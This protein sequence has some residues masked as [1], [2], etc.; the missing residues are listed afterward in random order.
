MTPSWCWIPDL[1][2]DQYE[3][4]IQS[5]PYCS[6]LQ[7]PQWSE[8]KSQWRVIRPA[9]L[10]ENRRILACGQVLIRPLPLGWSLWYMPFGPMLDYDEPKLLEIYLDQLVQE[11][12]KHPV[13]F[14]RIHPPVLVRE[15]RIEAFRKGEAQ[16]VTDEESLIKRF[17]TCGFA[18]RPRSFCLED[19]VQPRFQAVVR[20]E[21]WEEPPSSKIRYA[22]K[23]GERYRIQI[24]SCGEE[25]TAEFAR[26]IQLTEER[27][28]IILRNQTYFQ[29]LMQVYQE[30]ARYYLAHFQLQQVL[31]ETEAR[32]ESIESQQQLLTDTNPKKFRQLEEQRESCEKDLNFLRSINPTSAEAPSPSECLLDGETDDSALSQTAQPIAGILTLRYGKTAEMPYAG[33]DAQYSRIPS[34]WS[35]YVTGIREAFEAGCTRYNLGGVDGSL[36]DGLTRF[37][38][39]FN[40]TI[41]E[42]IGEFDYT[43]HPLLNRIFQW[44]NQKRRRCAQGR[45]NLGKD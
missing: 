22:L 12:R 35:L 43:A 15:G 25:G 30:K 45:S 32:L 27:Q 13:L 6:L 9:L 23:Q 19:T 1:P 34:M 21:D 18:L 44:L 8:V 10:D 11:S 31:Q 33:M 28:G 14:L 39:H 36:S 16:T 2:V 20:K 24:T 7:S 42:T 38:S 5:H 29:Q 17:Q 37:K 26:L 41:E 4:Y 3:P 40:P